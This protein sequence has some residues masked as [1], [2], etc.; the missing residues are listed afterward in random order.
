MNRRTRRKIK[1]N[2]KPK[3]LVRSPSFD[4]AIVGGGIAGL[5]CAYKLSNTFKVALFDDRSYIGGRIYTHPIGYEV[6]AARFNNSHRLL[7]DLIN[8][9]ELNYTQIPKNIDYIDESGKRINNSHEV[10]DSMLQKILNKTTVNNKLKQLSFYEHIVKKSSKEAA[11]L[12]VD[13]FG[14]HSEI[15]EMNAYDAYKTFKND[16]GNIQY[17]FLNEGLSELCNRMKKRIELNGSTVYLKKTIKTVVKKYD[18]YFILNEK[19]KANKVVFAVKPYQLKQFPILKPIH[20]HITSIYQAPL[21]RIYAIYKPEHNGKVWFNDLR[22]TTTNN[23]LRQI[24]PI[25]REKGLIMISYTDGKD[26]RPFVKSNFQLKSKSELKNIVKN[27]LKIVFPDINIP[28]PIY[29][30][31]H[32]WSVGCHHWKPGYNSKKIQKDIFNPVEDVFICGEG[33]SSKQAWMEGSLESAQAVVK[34]LSM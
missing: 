22:R 28:N 31:A 26:T 2:N 33:F 17:Y 15:K 14:Y 12:M 3:T 29:F 34:E 11:D 7:M 9:F 27:N 20:K 30:K 13:M 16:F 18:E 1:S 25:N 23:I 32:L 5:Y 4:I 10:F 21:I 19:F 24:I 6:G 8:S